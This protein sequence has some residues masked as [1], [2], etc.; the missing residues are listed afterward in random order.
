[1]EKIKDAYHAIISRETLYAAAHAAARGK[2]YKES[3]AGFNF[4]LEAEI[5]L[6]NRDLSAKSYR[7]GRYS[8][9][10]IFDPKERVISAAP[11]RDRVVHH[12][13][14]DY[15]EL[16]IDK[17]FIFDSYACR[18]GKGT[19]KAIN[20]AQKFTRANTYCLHGDV[21]KYFP[22]INHGV[23]KRLLRERIEDN[24][25]LWLLDE[26]IDSA[27]QINTVQGTGI[28][29]GNLTSQFFANL[30]L[31]EL[32]YFVKHTLRQRYYIRYMDDFLLFS[33][34]RDELCRFRDVIRTFIKENLLLTLHEGKSQVW[35]TNDGFKFLG[36]RFYKNYRRV[37]YKGVERFKKRMKL[38]SKLYEEGVLP[39]TRIQDSARCWAAHISYAAS[40]GLKDR[41]A[42]N[43]NKIVNNIKVAAVIS[44]ELLVNNP[45]AI[46]VPAEIYFGN[47]GVT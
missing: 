45:C 40:S 21:R 24:E 22:S 33:D 3:V 19:H 18:Q 2:R 34:N 20:R 38:Y 31:N 13:V 5:D 47:T 46:E 32:D 28:P 39:I 30:Y 7:P 11:F 42:G 26:I 10:K 4:N 37:S 29:I 15:I 1:M 8:V 35:K 23:L 25:L 43:M 6:L 17:T 36:F 44:E 27:N 9:F 14:H 12:A 41:M 16:M